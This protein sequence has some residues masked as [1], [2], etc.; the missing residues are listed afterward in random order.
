MRLGGHKP[1]GQKPD[2]QL[3]KQALESQAKNLQSELDLVRKRLGEIESSSEAA[4]VD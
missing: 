1:P 3:E 4:Q 2:P